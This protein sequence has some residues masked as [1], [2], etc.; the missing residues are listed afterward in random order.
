MLHRELYEIH[1]VTFN[2]L[3]IPRRIIYDTSGTISAYSS[4][5]KIKN[6]DD[7]IYI[8]CEPLQEPILLGRKNNQNPGFCQSFRSRPRHSTPLSGIFFTCYKFGSASALF[9]IRMIVRN[10][11]T[12]PLQG[13]EEYFQRGLEGD[14]SAFAC[15]LSIS[16]SISDF[17]L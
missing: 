17:C 7:K 2:F 4:T 14:G 3:S 9:M 8:K 16:R 13:Q 1:S 15:W 11:L 6:E 5:V 10:K 12:I